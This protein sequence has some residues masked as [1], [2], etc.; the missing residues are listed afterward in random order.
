M[1]ISAKAALA[2]TPRAVQQRSANGKVMIL[3]DQI[4]NPTARSKCRSIYLRVKLNND[5]SS[6]LYHSSQI[7]I[8]GKAGDSKQYLMRPDS[9]LWVHCRC[10]YFLYYCEQALARIKASSIY[11]CRPELRGKGPTGILRNPNLVPYLCKHLYAAVLALS[12]VES[13]Q[14]S[15]KEFVNTRNP[16]DGNYDE[17]MP[18]SY[19][20]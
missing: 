19:T 20:R 9:R 5:A 14:T 6:H 18:P 17:K 3:L 4:E 8:Y 12:K 16:Y 15:Y 11:D 2:L 10:P 13:G 1:Y 7:R